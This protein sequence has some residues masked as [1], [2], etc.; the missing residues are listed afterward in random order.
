M[1]IHGIVSTYFGDL[2]YDIGKS[3][4]WTQAFCDSVYIM[5]SNIADTSRQYVV[6]WDHLY[7]RAKYS[8]FSSHS[9]FG[10]PDTA[11]DW[12]QESFVRASDAWSYDD[13]DWVMFIDG[14]ECL[15]VYHAPPEEIA[16]ESASIDGPTSTLT[17]T[18]DGPHGMVVGSRIRIE[19]ALLSVEATDPGYYF[20]TQDTASEEWVIEHGL[21][22]IPSISEDS[23]ILDPDTENGY[24]I[25]YPDLNTMVLTFE[26]AVAGSVD[27]E[28]EAAP[29]T[30]YDL[31]GLF[32]VSDVPDIDAFSIVDTGNVYVTYP[33]TP[34]DDPA[35]GTFTSEPTGYWDG[36][37]F[38]S[39][40]FDEIRNAE[41][42]GK[43]QI[44][45]DAWAMIRS[46]APEKLHFK[47]AVTEFADAI[48][49][50]EVD[51]DDDLAIPVPRCDE[52]YLP[53]DRLIR[54]AKVSALRDPSFDWYTLDQPETSFS[55]AYPADRL[56]LISYA[57]IRWA[58]TPTDMTQAVDPDAPH[59]VA[60]D[61][62]DPPLR[63]VTIEADVG[64][65]MRRFI[66]TVR[67]ASGAPLIWS[68]LDGPGEQP[69]VGDYQ[70]LDINYVEIYED[71]AFIGYLPYGG[72]PL[73]P[74]VLR[75]NQREG[76]WY[77]NQGG[78][79][80]TVTIATVA[81]DGGVATVTTKNRHYFPPGTKI[82]VFGSNV[83]FDPSDTGYGVF[84][85]SWTID[86]AP[87]SY[88]FTFLRD[89]GTT[90]LTVPPTT[91]ALAT[92]TSMPQT[93]GPIPWNY[94][95][96]EFLISD[97]VNWVKSGNILTKIS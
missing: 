29:A 47:L 76:V 53:M 5:D 40:L 14:T 94:L 60:G 22:G 49:N 2:E 81:Y 25:S 54:I 9:F 66:S 46:T 35:L 15:N 38:Q 86:T 90:I 87:D 18:T 3:L 44:S 56:S 4:N 26:A 69:M 23:L 79:P 52:F 48:P 85:G 59:Y 64:F 72:T 11:A 78:V 50:L 37:L 16:I 8:F 80:K 57:Y 62:L 75:S 63:P 30:Q 31:D 92:A 20:H 97:P 96:N 65:A 39:W 42:D 19:E 21:G 36:L 68:E 17:F 71:G 83:S 1:A 70:K 61:E 34:L 77:I 89:P 12:R 33:D 58:E 10:S 28:T 51:A 88:T 7:P 74:G 6:D 13:D 82:T 67:M 91:M 45:L 73:Y 41:S 93:Y 43:D 55:Q 24:E 27:V 84:D 95:L 32:F